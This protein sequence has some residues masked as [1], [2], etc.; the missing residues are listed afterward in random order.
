M[1]FPSVRELAPH[2]AQWVREE[3]AE[4][5][6]WPASARKAIEKA[7]AAMVIAEQ[8]RSAALSALRGRVCD[9][10]TAAGK[11]FAEANREAQRLSIVAG[12]LRAA[13]TADV[14]GS[15]EVVRSGG[16]YIHTYTRVQL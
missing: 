6:S 15:W 5:D 11:E 10:R 1:S 9:T 16:Y 13:A 7:E 8:R 14:G 2:A 12:N 3:K 4:R